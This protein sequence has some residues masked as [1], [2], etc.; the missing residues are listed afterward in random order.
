[1]SWNVESKRLE[2]KKFVNKNAR[3]K[4]LLGS[5]IRDGFFEEKKS[6]TQKNFKNT[7]A[8]FVS[9]FLIQ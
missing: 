1:M 9:K 5:F 2:L 8:F 4:K 7:S 6:H 3:L